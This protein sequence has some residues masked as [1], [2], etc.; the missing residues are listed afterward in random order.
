MPNLDFMTEE[1][2][3][4]GNYEH[5]DTRTIVVPFGLEEGAPISMHFIHGLSDIDELVRNKAPE[6]A[7]KFRIQSIDGCANAIPFG[8]EESL[9]PVNYYGKRAA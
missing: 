6:G 2:F 5:L 4:S 1:D 9:V 3:S 7:V 8:R